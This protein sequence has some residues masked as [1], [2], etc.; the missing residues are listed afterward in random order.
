[1]G[2]FLYMFFANRAYVSFFWTYTIGF[3][4]LVILVILFIIGFVWIRKIAKIEV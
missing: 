2:L 3:V 4:A 1:V